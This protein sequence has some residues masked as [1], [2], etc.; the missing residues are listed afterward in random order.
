MLNKIG[1]SKNEL[2]ELTGYKLAKR[3]CEALATMDIP[4]KV[5]PNGT[6]FV[7]VSDIRKPVEER[8]NSHD[9]VLNLI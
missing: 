9:L 2:H 6:P 3:Q 7:S 8:H 4:F 1:L 5:R